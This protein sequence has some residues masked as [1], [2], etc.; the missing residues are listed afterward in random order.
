LEFI[1]VYKQNG[2][3]MCELIVKLNGECQPAFRCCC[4]TKYCDVLILA[5]Y[6]K[7]EYFDQVQWPLGLNQRPKIFE[8]HTNKTLFKYYILVSKLLFYVRIILSF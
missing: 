7:N 1:I 5:N 6:K 2:H 8:Y 3:G 4:D